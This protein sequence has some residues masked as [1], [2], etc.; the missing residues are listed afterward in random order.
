MNQL[1]ESDWIFRKLPLF[2]EG[3]INISVVVLKI[4]FLGDVYANLFI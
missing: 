1:G 3:V 4:Y 2:G